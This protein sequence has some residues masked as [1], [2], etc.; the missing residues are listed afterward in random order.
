MVIKEFTERRAR[1]QQ[2]GGEASGA[3]APASASAPSRAPKD[4]ISAEIVV[5]KDSQKGIIIG[6][7]GAMLR[8][9]GE[10]ARKEVEAFL[11]RGVY[12]EL[13]VQV[14]RGRGRRPA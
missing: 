8:R 11:E 5:E 6:R 9:I 10:A 14:G 3:P 12:L 13:S 2:L 4:F 7:E 1:R